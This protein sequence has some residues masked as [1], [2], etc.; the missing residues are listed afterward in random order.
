MLNG[1]GE[2]FVDEGAEFRN[3]TYAK[4][5]GKTKGRVAVEPEY[6]LKRLETVSWWE[7]D[8]V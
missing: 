7:F 2:R 3:Y 1:R 8:R 4:T 5:V 6:S